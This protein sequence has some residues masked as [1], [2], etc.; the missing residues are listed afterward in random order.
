MVTNKNKN[1]FKKKGTIDN[2][3]EPNISK[4]YL[5]DKISINNGIMR[6][7]RILCTKESNNPEFQYY[8]ENKR[9]C[10]FSRTNY[11]ARNCGECEFGIT[12]LDL[13]PAKKKYEHDWKIRL[14]NWKW[15]IDNLKY[16]NSLNKKDNL[17]SP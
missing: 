13:T 3:S 2:I 1:D 15:P 14:S 16:I 7:K 9:A 4:E 11:N 8:S 6:T 12:I 17:R 10:E 5:N